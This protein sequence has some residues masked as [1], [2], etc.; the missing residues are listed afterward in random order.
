MRRVLKRAL[1]AAAVALLL[2]IAGAIIRVAI[3]LD[4]PTWTATRRLAFALDGA[5]EVVLIETAAKVEIARKVATVEEI[6]RLRRS[7]TTWP[8]PFYSKGSL[9]FLPHH[10]IEIHAADGSTFTCNICF[11]C[12]EL[13]TND[14]S[15]TEESIRFA[16]IPP[17]LAEPLA[18]FFTSIGMPPKTME[19]YDEIERA[20]AVTAS[21]LEPVSQ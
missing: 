9:C 4:V 18:V 5:R 12:E 2:V 7:L 8:R 20:H 17:Y 14:G 1:I 3:L 16:L 10:A 11:L 15:H 13:A 6:S 21:Q 19:E